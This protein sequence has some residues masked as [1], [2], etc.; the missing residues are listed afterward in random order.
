[1]KKQLVQLTVGKRQFNLKISWYENGSLSNQT[2][3]LSPQQDGI[4]IQCCKVKQ[5]A[6]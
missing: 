2:F 3:L 4:F 1:M 5:I 6:L